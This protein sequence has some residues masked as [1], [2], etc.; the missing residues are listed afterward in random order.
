MP[1]KK[2]ALQLVKFIAL[3]SRPGLMNWKSDRPDFL[4]GPVPEREFDN[5]RSLEVPLKAPID[6]LLGRR[7]RF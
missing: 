2:T 1:G 7:E 3:T 6:K 4:S 5:F